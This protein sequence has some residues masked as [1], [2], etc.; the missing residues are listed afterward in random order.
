MFIDFKWRQDDV[1]NITLP[2]SLLLA[3][4]TFKARIK[5]LHLTS[6]STIFKRN[7]NN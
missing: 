7:I 5:I 3:G 4:L 1:K 2:I 6:E